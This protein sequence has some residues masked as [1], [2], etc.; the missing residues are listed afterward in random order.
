MHIFRNLTNITHRFTLYI[1]TNISYN[2]QIVTKYIIDKILHYRKQIH[3]N[4][5]LLI[6]RAKDKSL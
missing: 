6:E 1:N 5:S 3:K 2:T 4:D